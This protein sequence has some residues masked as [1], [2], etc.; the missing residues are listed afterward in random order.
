MRRSSGNGECPWRGGS[1]C[2]VQPVTVT[3]LSWKEPT[4]RVK[5]FDRKGKRLHEASLNLD[6]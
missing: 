2:P 4:L 1:R 5:I 6:A 3:R